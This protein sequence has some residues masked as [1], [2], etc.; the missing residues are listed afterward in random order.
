MT[1]ED[2]LADISVVS[3]GLA[4]LSRNYCPNEVAEILGSHE[5]RA[6]VEHFITA[7][8]FLTLFRL[9]LRSRYNIAVTI[10]QCALGSLLWEGHQ[11][12]ERGYFQYGQF[13]SDLSGYASLLVCYNA[14]EIKNYFKS[15]NF[16]GKRK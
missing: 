8:S 11:S 7:F 12:L 3:L 4:F 2:K 5:T 9:S 16:F 14:N 1:L 15:K 13:A 6:A 10:G